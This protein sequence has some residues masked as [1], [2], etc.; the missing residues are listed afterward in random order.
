MNKHTAHRYHILSI[1][2]LLI[3]SIL[4]C[5]SPTLILEMTPP[6]TSKE[7][8]SEAEQRE[9]GALLLE[10]NEIG[11]LTLSSSGG[12]FWA[13]G[14]SFNL[15]QNTLDEDF[16]LSVTKASAF[17][18]LP[19]D[20]GAIWTPIYSLSGI[21]TS[22][23]GSLDISIPLSE[24]ILAIVKGNPEELDKVWLKVGVSAYEFSTNEIYTDFLPVEDAILDLEAGTL[25]ATISF[26]NLPVA[27]QKVPNRGKLACPIQIPTRQ[28]FLYEQMDVR[29]TGYYN[30]DGYTYTANEH[31]RI[32]HQRWYSE[33][34]IQN[35]L[36][37][38]DNAYNKAK[39][40]GFDL[41]HLKS[42]D[43][44][45]EQLD[46]RKYFGFGEDVQ[47]DGGFDY[48]L[49]RGFY[50]TFNTR[51][52]SFDSSDP[53]LKASAGHEFFHYVQVSSYSQFDGYSP[54]AFALF[55]EATATWFEQ[56]VLEDPNWVPSVA[57]TNKNFTLKSLFHAQP[58]ADQGYG[59][60]WL[61]EYLANTYGLEFIRDTYFSGG[62]DSKS[63]WGS[64]IR[65]RMQHSFPYEYIHF[66][67][68]YLITPEKFSDKLDVQNLQSHR[69]TPQHDP[70]TGQLSIVEQVPHGGSGWSVDTT[71]TNL[72]VEGI[73]EPAV[74]QMN[75]SLEDL[76]GRL[77]GI[78]F[79][80]NKI[81]PEVQSKGV[82]SI[83]VVAGDDAGV[84]VYAVPQ[85]GS[86]AN[87]VPLAG[88]DNFLSNNNPT[89]NV[90]FSA[91]GGLG[92]YQEV[93]LIAFYAR[94]GEEPSSTGISIHI[95]YSL[96]MQRAMTLSGSGIATDH[97]YPHTICNVMP[98]GA[99]C[100]IDESP[101]CPVSGGG[102]GGDADGC[103]ACLETPT[104]CESCDPNFGAA[105]FLHEWRPENGSEPFVLEISLDDNGQV[106]GINDF[107]GPI[108]KFT[109]GVTPT[110]S[111]GGTGFQMEWRGLI[112]NNNNG[113]YLIYNGMIT[114]EGGSGTWTLG[115]AGPG[116]TVTGTWEVGP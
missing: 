33:K 74:I 97:N 42:I 45:I 12:E 79:A 25:S 52:V 96:Q 54:E 36:G 114:A 19:E 40:L 31:F 64:T 108:N 100:C 78:R 99:S 34:D 38:L 13:D 29:A 71:S 72:T 102:G 101:T 73:V 106:T 75:T 27:Y 56:Y 58:A 28:D 81:T 104:W 84:M 8:T 115:H 23:D 82:L 77:V 60:S 87:A 83:D 93:A 65:S 70:E 26:G 7:I 2:I 112:D 66:L 30:P 80:R 105:L 37:Y 47:K 14:A 24:E 67:P 113:G 103:P 53:K 98:E 88:P 68:E 41:S 46:Y 49:W 76:T 16:E 15:G 50:L 11:S 91:Q 92:N 116:V 6:D 90:S 85:G 44:Y 63:A 18:T 62:L 10:E 95:E 69:F 22:F 86:L 110:F 107:N 109:F 39:T 48:S 89:L 32:I 59:A 1:S 111:Q 57:D 3:L 35:L 55:D 43:V 9:D 51:L 20:E 5:N 21:P 61:V 94:N 4:A 17:A